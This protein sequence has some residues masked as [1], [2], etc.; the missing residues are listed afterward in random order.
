MTRSTFPV[1]AAL[2]A[3]ALA[4]LV[5]V[6]AC[7]GD[8]AEPLAP[9]PSAGEPVVVRFERA[10]GSPSDDARIDDVLTVDAGG[11]VTVRDMAR[12]RLAETGLTVDERLELL[13][14]LDEAGFRSLPDTLRGAACTDCPERSVTRGVGSAQ[15]TVVLEGDPAGLPPGVR[16]LVE[17]LEGLQLRAMAARAAASGSGGT[18][19]VRLGNGIDLVLAVGAA[20]VEPG[21]PLYLQLVA[22]NVGDRPASL[23]YATSRLFDFRVE[24]LGGRLVWSLSRDRAFLDVDT[25]VTLGP[26]ESRRFEE[27]WR[28]VDDRGRPVASG[29]YLAVGIVPAANGGE[30]P[31]VP[32]TVR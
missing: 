7:G 13:R 25:K 17:R 22:T 19:L 11:R 4:V 26:G 18:S 8:G 23:D 12:G 32:F 30:T 27:V 2:P 10:G 3:L 21:E 6:A 24:T 20:R 29:R 1:S 16:R 15:R 5:A 9:T 31:P 14:A 28:G